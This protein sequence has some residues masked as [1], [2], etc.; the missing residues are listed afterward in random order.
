[1]RIRRTWFG[2]G[3]VRVVVGICVTQSENASN[4]FVI[5]KE[6]WRLK[7]LRMRL[8]SG[9]LHQF[10]LAER[11]TTRSFGRRGS[12]RM[13]AFSLWVTA[14]LHELHFTFPLGIGLNTF[15]SAGRI[16]LN[17]YL[18]P[19]AQREGREVTSGE[20]LGVI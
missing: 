17:I 14:Q 20:G 3:D 4:D 15:I 2:S 11:K 5:L 18:H 12:L 8:V 16:S 9:D 13:T 6:P 19:P 1:M 10:T 7:D